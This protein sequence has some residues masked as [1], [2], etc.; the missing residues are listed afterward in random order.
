MTD[1][2]QYRVTAGSAAGLVESI[3]RAVAL[4][5]LQPGERLPSVRRLAAE[6][7]LSPV[8]VASALTE[9]RRRGV[10]VSEPRRGTR[11]GERPPIGSTRAA[12]PV[13]PGAR[14]LS[15]GNP[16][17]ALLPDLGRALAGTDLPPRLYGEPAALPELAELARERFAADGIEGEAPCIVSGALDGIER[18]LDAHV[19]PGDRVAVENP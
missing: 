5:E 12:L 19:R 15:Q 14:D 10:V 1:L 11:V 2:K 13:P 18:A 17:P 7:A 6:V 16:D 4:G 8:T 3:E 9:L